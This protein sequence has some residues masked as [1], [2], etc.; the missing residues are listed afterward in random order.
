MGSCDEKVEA[1]FFPGI[2]LEVLGDE[3]VSAEKRIRLKWFCRLY[4]KQITIKPPFGEY[5]LFLPKLEVP[6]SGF[7]RGGFPGFPLGEDSSILG[8]WVFFWMIR[9]FRMFRCFQLA[10]KLATNRC[11]W[12]LWCMFFQI[13][14]LLLVVVVVVVLV[15]LVVL[16]LLL[17]LL[18][19]MMFFQQHFCCWFYFIS[20]R[21]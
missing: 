11:G 9:C 19:F 12:I 18:N 8:T 14:L 2:W 16:L 7:L 13:C 21:L 5:V 17:L 15:V 10:A 3:I 20:C 4:Q 6:R 1:V